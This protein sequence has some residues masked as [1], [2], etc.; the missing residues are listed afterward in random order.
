MDQRLQTTS[1]EFF[2]YIQKAADEQKAIKASG[3]EVRRTLDRVNKS[4]G[5]N[6]QAR[7]EMAN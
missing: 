7:S 1:E 2:A 4:Q 5:Q 6:E 3:D